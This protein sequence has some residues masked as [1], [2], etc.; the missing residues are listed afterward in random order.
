MHGMARRRAVETIDFDPADAGDVVE[1]MDQLAAAGDGWI[2][3][4]PGVPE[5]EVEQPSGSIFSALFGTA[6]P[7]VSMGTWMPAG[8]PAAPAGRAG[9]TGL[10]ARRGGDAT[11]T[12]GIMHARGR[13]A[14]SQLGGAGSPVPPGWRVA[15]DHPRRGLIV[16]PPRGAPHREVLGWTLRAGAALSVAPLTGKWRAR[17]YLPRSD[18]G[19]PNRRG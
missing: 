10:I 8:V 4:L 15:Q 2:N 7:A 9:P 17:V 14:V 12:V 3:L 16:H 1:E 18:R 13:D 19:T 6:Q 5:E 11:E